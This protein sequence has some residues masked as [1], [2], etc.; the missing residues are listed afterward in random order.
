[1]VM[2]AVGMCKWR[3]KLSENLLPQEKVSFFMQ[4]TVNVRI[5]LFKL[6][7]HSYIKRASERALKRLELQTFSDFRFEKW[8]I[9]YF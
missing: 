8:K 1:M 2:V 6:T 7:F 9:Q 4:I 5:L 3:L